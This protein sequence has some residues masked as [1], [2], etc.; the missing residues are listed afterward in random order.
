MNKFFLYSKVSKGLKEKWILYLL[1]SMYPCALFARN[2]SFFTRACFVIF[3]TLFRY[4]VP[5]ILF[6]R[7]PQMI[8]IFYFIQALGGFHIRKAKSFISVFLKLVL[9]C[10]YDNAHNIFRQISS[11]RAPCAL[12]RSCECAKRTY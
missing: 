5:Q 9:L 11:A 6:V 4:Q 2:R 8:I 12:T 3:V 7:L 10:I 1:D